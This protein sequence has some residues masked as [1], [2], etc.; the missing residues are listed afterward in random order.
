MIDV[1]YWP[2][3]NG[4]KITI[5]LEEMELPYHIVPVNPKTGETSNPDFLLINPN[6]KIP[7]IIDRSV[8][9]LAIFESAAILQYLAEKSGKLM[10]RDAAGKY[11]VIQ[12][13]TFQAANVGP[14]MGQFAHFHD[15]ARERIQYALN[16]YG[17][18]TERLYG[19]IEKRLRES[20]YI[21]GDTFSVADVSLWPWIAPAR[22]E[23][24]WEDWPNI[25]DWHDRIGARP[26]VARGNAVR[27]DLQ[28]IGV[29]N[30]TDEQWN[31]LYGWQQNP[32]VP[33]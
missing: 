28:P 21:A 9:K 31:S 15:Y 5:A 11:S 32:R 30:L 13:L 24:R 6:G 10:P 33:R 18:E 12:W 1:Y 29:Q 27:L 17:R 26:A 16:R 8:G 20:P 22:Q 4:R 14:M 19:V 3:I 23:Q 2:T 7:A 25:K